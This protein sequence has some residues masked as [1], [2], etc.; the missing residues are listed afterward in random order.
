MMKIQFVQTRHLV[1]IVLAALAGSLAAIAVCGQ[2]PQTPLS[3]FTERPINAIGY[4]IG[5]GSTKIDL[6]NSGLIAGAEGQA[7]VE[8][9]PAVTNVEA[10]IEGLTPP[11]SLGA[12]FLTYVLWVVSPNGR[13]INLGE[14]QFDKNGRGALKA[15]TQLQSFSLFLTAEPYS[16]VRQPSEMVVLENALRKNT[17][18]KILV[19][20]KYPLIKR[21]QYE[22]LANPLALS[23]DTKSVPIE[24]YEARNA[25]EIAKSR[26]AGTYAS[27]ILARAEGG[28]SQAENALSRKA[29][30]KEVIS[31][32]RLSAQS[33]EDARA[34]AVEKRE[35][36]RIATE[37]AAAAAAAK[38]EAEEKAAREAAEAKRRADE[39]ARRQSELAAARQAQLRAEAAAKEAQLKAEAAAKE[40]RMRAEAAVADAKAKAES[41]ALR[42]REQAAKADAERAN[43]A[44][45]EL[46]ARLLDQF[47]RIL[48]TQDTSRGLVITMADVLFDP[49]KYNLRPQTR[50]QLAKV[51]GI[52]LAHPGLRLDVEGH[53]DNTGTEELNQTL[54]E[55]RA[56]AVREYLIDQGLSGEKITARGLGEAMPVASNDTSVGRQKNRRVELIV[57]GEVIGTS[58]TDAKR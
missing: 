32:A 54:S 16:A 8:A 57:S 20:D 22:K 34:L 55:Q 45:Q 39:E 28:L 12:E 17:K 42:A 4:Q 10:Q 53:T 1:Q 29:S 11:T 14:I 21:N 48:Q 27:E 6:R 50:E 26:G 30:R 2:T 47:N 35:E 56:S 36:E 5:E 15:T 23:M 31:L 51:S 46:R 40:A 37:R 25:L 13:A 52:L 9:R 58:L 3:A 38:S 44:A 43:R 7:K 24:L 41:E 18:G 19:V 49:G 33:S